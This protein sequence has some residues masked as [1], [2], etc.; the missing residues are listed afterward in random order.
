MEMRDWTQAQNIIQQLKELG[1]KISIDDFGTGFSS[2]AYLLTIKANE[3]KIDRSLV[4]EIESSEQARLVLAS[5]LDIARNLGMQV[6]VEGVETPAQ[7][8]IVFDLGARRAQGY[9]YG[10]PVPPEEA[11]MEATPQVH[12]AHSRQAI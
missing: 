9:L 8:D 10:K 5:V 4:D 6:V 2:L 1:P 7:R 11:L 12:T 3:L